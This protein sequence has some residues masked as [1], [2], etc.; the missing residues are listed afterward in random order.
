[1]GNTNKNIIQSFVPYHAHDILGDFH[2]LWECLKV[3][4][5]IFW[6]TPAQHGSLS[7][8]RESVRWL[9]VDKKVKIFNVGDEFLMH[10]FKAHLVAS[11]CSLLNITCTPDAIPHENSIQWLRSTAE[12]LGVNTLMPMACNNNLHRAFLHIA[13]L[14]VDLREAIRYENGPH[15]VRHWKLWLPRFVGTG[16]KNYAIEAIQLVANLKADFPQHL[17]YII[18]NNRTVNIQGKIGHG[19]PID[20]MVEHYNL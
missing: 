14:Y 1:M 3:I 16:R 9:Q 12:R 20:Q 2:F 6:G 15:I 5:D 11:I 17:A 8:M 19:K 10:V 4:F 18:T 7:N 13:Y